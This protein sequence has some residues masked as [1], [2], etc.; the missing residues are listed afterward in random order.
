M[1][2]ET[3]ERLD[4]ED[5]YGD[6]A[7]RPV[8]ELVALICR[9]LGLD[10]DWTRLAEEA[11]AQDEIAEAPVGSPFNDLSS[12]RPPPFTGEGD[13]EVVERAYRGTPPA[14]NPEPPHGASP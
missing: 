12:A 7:S 4:D 2:E 5:I 9:D 14:F 10:P 13:H 1:I 3:G 8:G 11:W 6:V